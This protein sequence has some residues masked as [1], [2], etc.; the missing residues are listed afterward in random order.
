MIPQNFI[1]QL[2]FPYP[3][4]IICNKSML[5][6]KMKVIKKIEPKSKLICS[7]GLSL[8]QYSLTSAESRSGT[9]P[10]LPPRYKPWLN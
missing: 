1:S 7:I 8:A 3:L 2:D 4:P 6:S 9:P 5:N 10:M